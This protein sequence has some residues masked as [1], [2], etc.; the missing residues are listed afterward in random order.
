VQKPAELIALVPPK[1]ASNQNGFIDGPTTGIIPHH[2]FFC[3]TD[4]VTVAKMQPIRNYHG[5]YVEHDD[6]FEMLLCFCLFVTCVKSGSY[7]K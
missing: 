3:L 2:R 5:Q 1:N 7:E 4:D 6:F